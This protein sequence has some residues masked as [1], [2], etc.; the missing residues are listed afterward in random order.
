MSRDFHLL[1]S[2]FG[3]EKILKSREKW[4]EFFFSENCE[5]TP[6][7]EN[8][9]WMKMPVVFPLF[10]YF[11]TSKSYASVF[12]ARR[13]EK[14]FLGAFR[15]WN[16]W[17]YFSTTRY[18]KARVGGRRITWFWEIQFL[19]TYFIFWLSGKGLNSGLAFYM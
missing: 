12:S 1:R 13:V 17:L 15:I 3:R 5:V 4:D 11:L 2:E 18:F 14:V 10:V 9:L 6:S 8:E 19:C 7:N 16:F